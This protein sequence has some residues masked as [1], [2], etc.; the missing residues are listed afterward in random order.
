MSGRPSRRDAWRSVSRIGF[1]CF[2]T[3]EEK[4]KPWS[5]CTAPIRSTWPPRTTDGVSCPVARFATK[6]V[7]FSYGM[8]CA[9]RSRIC[10]STRSR[11]AGAWIKRDSSESTSS[12]TGCRRSPASL[13]ACRARMSRLW[14]LCAV[15][16]T[17][18]ERFWATERS[19]R[20]ASPVRSFS[21]SSPSS[22]RMRRSFCSPRRN[23]SVTSCSC[24]EPIP[25]LRRIVRNSLPWTPF[26]SDPRSGRAVRPPVRSVALLPAKRS[27]GPSLGPAAGGTGRAALALRPPG[28]KTPPPAGSTPAHARAAPRPAL[29]APPAG[30]ELP[31]RPPSAPPARR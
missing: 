12:S 8:P 15:D 20:S 21:V 30:G 7:P 23:F 18:E 31:L 10:A 11:S 13:S 14:M 5:K 28:R 22:S 2:A 25:F 24:C 4:P 19:T 9:I 1:F 29:R 26:P 6:S 17:S 16:S 27:F 3:Q